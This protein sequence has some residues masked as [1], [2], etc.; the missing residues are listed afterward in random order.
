MPT[1][2]SSPAAWAPDPKCPSGRVHQSVA[3]GPHLNPRVGAHPH[4]Q[5]GCLGAQTKSAWVGTQPDQ[6]LAAP[7]S[8]DPKQGMGSQPKSKAEIGHTTQSTAWLLAGD[9]TQKHL[10]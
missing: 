7:S 10:F 9:H 8:K 1:L 2:K 6:W 4:K 5:P 3:W